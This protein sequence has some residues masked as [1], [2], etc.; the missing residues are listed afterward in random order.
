M[1]QVATPSLTISPE[2]FDIMSTKD[3]SNL[4][5]HTLL[6]QPVPVLTGVANAGTDLNISLPSHQ[7]ILEVSSFHLEKVRGYLGI[8]ATV[9]VRVV[10]NADKYTQGRICLSYLAKGDQVVKRRKDHRHVTQ[11]PHVDLDLNTDTEVV[12]RIPHRGPYTH[13][14]IPRKRYNTGTFQVTNLL[15]HIGNPYN[16]TVYMSFEDVDLLGPTG[17]DIPAVYQGDLSKEEKNIPLS[18]KVG[19]LSSAMTMLSGVPI[20][21]SIAQPIAWASG[22]ASGVLS[23]F[24]WSRPLSTV[25]PDVYFKR[26]RLKYNQ[27]DGTDIADQMA[28]TTTTGVRCSDQVGLTTQDEM[29]FAYLLGIKSV[30]FRSFYETTTLAGTRI[31]SFELNPWSMQSDSDITGARIMHPAA[32]MANVFQ[33]YRGSFEMTFSLAKT[34][35]HS[36]RLLVVFEPYTTDLLSGSRPNAR[37]S[38][39]EQAI[40]CHKDIIDIR[41]GSEFTLRFPFTAL[42]PYLNT[43]QAYGR[44]HIFILNPLVRNDTA[45]SSRVDYSVSIKCCEDFE[46][47]T[48]IVPRFFPVKVT[49]AT[50]SIDL[51]SRNDTLKE[52]AYQSGLE[53]GDK[54]I[55][56]KNIGTTTIPPPETTMSQLCIGEKILSAKQL[57]MRSKITSAPEIGAVTVGGLCPYDPFAVDTFVDASVTVPL[58]S[59]HFQHDFYS[60]VACMYAYT[61]GGAVLTLNNTTSNKINLGLTCDHYLEQGIATHGEWQVIGQVLNKASDRFYIPPYGNSFCRYAEPQLYLGPSDIN[62]TGGRDYEHGYSS[63]KVFY[64]DDIDGQTVMVNT[65]RSAADDTQFGTFTGVPYV[66][67]RKPFDGNPNEN[68]RLPFIFPNS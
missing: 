39:I 44:V 7:R 27:T 22:V 20:L 16:L 41:Q 24:G 65:S 47:A 9:V 29:S 37:V 10:V 50:T 3:W 55:L 67:Y 32:Y 33:K 28:L 58:T 56:N 18:E 62:G 66:A 8:R 60:Y 34:I 26:A 38:T 12:L 54:E 68:R 59:V 15:P 52:V 49:D 25:T 36:G 30:V 31:A 53:V 51:F 1:A 45:V 6:S 43:D 5:L 11:L 19:M 42:V 21:T 64:F 35:F 17:T 13:F 40:N 23:A 57:A 46:F 2:K 48:P 14:D 63:V 4:D 61:R